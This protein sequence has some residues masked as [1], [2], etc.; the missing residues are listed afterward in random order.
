MSV[1]NEQNNEGSI[2]HFF[3]K[4]RMGEQIGAEAL[5]LRYLPRLL[6]LA[7]RTLNGRC[8]ATTAPDDVVQSAFVSFWKRASVGDFGTW[9]NRNDIWNLLACITVRKA[10]QTTRRALTLKRGGGH[11]LNESESPDVNDLPFRLEEAIAALPTDKFDLCCEE[12]LLALD[13]ETR[14]VVVLRL[15]GH[16]NREAADILVCAERTVER[17][18]ELARKVWERQDGEE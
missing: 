17:K 15:M 6:S 4:V 16:T 10:H 1:Q 2:T 7:S 9:L 18:L 11:V 3:Q 14:A 12:Y 13:D 5:W 8:R